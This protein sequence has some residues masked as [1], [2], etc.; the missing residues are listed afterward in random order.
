MIGFYASLTMCVLVQ[1]MRRGYAQERRED[2]V[3]CD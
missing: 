1:A 3:R 2:V